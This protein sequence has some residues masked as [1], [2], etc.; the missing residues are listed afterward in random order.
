M[1]PDTLMQVPADSLPLIKYADPM[2][3]AE[4]KNSIARAEIKSDNLWMIFS[5]VLLFIMLTGF[6]CLET[7]L[8]RSKNAANVLFKNIFIPVISILTF[9]GWG[10]SLLYPGSEYQGT[11]IGFPQFG[12]DSDEFGYVSV[13]DGQ[14][15]FGIFF[16]YQALLSAIAIAVI[17]GTVSE[18]IKLPAFLIFIFIFAGIIYP[19]TGM[20]YWGGGWLAG[21]P[22]GPK[23]HD[24]AGT[25]L[26]HIVGGV[27]ALTA[28]AMLGPRIGKYAEGKIM[29]I[30]GHN[31]PL[32]GIGLFLLWFGWIGFSGG[33]LMSA[34]PDQLSYVLL[35]TF[36]A[37]VSGC[38]GAFLIS[39]FIY[40]THD[41]TMMMNG[42]LA[43]LV[44]ISASA[45]IMTPLES[46]IIGFIAGLLVVFSVLIFDK[47]HIDDPMGA[48]SVHLVCGIWGILAIGIFGPLAGKDQF[49]SQFIGCTTIII[50]VFLLSSIVLF[51]L[52]K[53]I[54]LRV[55]RKKELEGLDINEHGMQAYNLDAG[56][57]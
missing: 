20:W 51:L 14:I 37:S 26:V 27:G 47:L 40:K 28:A 33:A 46:I 39:Y 55:S 52:K 31:L 34:S 53:T 49:I 50:C 16:L 44:A 48:V 54:G 32:A 57:N 56:H 41:I 6:A 12:I 13:V 38:I 36:F 5:I 25:A 23:F 11:F 9:A 45:D 3:L 29:P 43:G 10:F 24:F 21:N 22:F 19:I 30:M 8:T 2:V 17:S 42:I 35:I 18:R 1:I 4:L 15:S 7:G